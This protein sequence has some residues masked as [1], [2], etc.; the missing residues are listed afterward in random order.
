MAEKEKKQ[1]FWS[2]LF[3][4]PTKKKSVE[5]S[6]SANQEEKKQSG[7]DLET[8]SNK[9]LVEAEKIYKKGLSTIKDVIAPASMEILY[10]HIKMWDGI[11]KSFFVYSYPRFIDDN[12]LSP[13]I[14]MDA[15][16]DISMFIYPHESAAI[17]RL[18]RNKVAQMQSTINM[19]RESGRVR[20][21]GVEAALEDAENLRDQLQRGEEK[22]FQ[23]WLYFSI[24][25][26]EDK[27]M[28]K[29]ITQLET[30]L[31]S[32]LVLTKRAS[33]QMERAYNS[34]LP[35]CYD[36]L[37]ITRNMNTSPLSSSFPFS[38]SDLSSDKW[39]MYWINRHNDSL[40]IFDRFSLPN[41]NS[42]V[43]ST[44]WAWKSYTVKLE[45]LR[46]MMF[47]TD[48]IVIDPENEYKEL[49][50]TV[51]WTFISLS[52]NSREKINPFDLPQWLKDQQEQAWD[53]LRS[54]II[55][56][57]WILSLMLGSMTPEESS[58]IDKALIN[59][60]ALKW[61]TFDI[62]DPSWIEVP[63]MEDLY[64]VLLTTKGAESL[65]KRLE[66]YVNW[67]YSWI[68]NKPTNIDLWSWMIV[69]NVRDLEEELRPMAMHMLLNYIWNKVRSQLKKRILVVDEAWKIMQ[70][71][72]SAKFLFWLVK[73]A[74]KYYLWVTTIT[75]DVEDFMSSPY[76]KPI[77]TN[78]SMQILLKQA[79][80]SLDV[81]QKT[82]NLTEWEK[83]LLLN[84]WVWQGIFFAGNKHAAIQI[85]ASY[86]EDK[87][88]T[89][90]PEQILKRQ[91]EEVK[92]EK[93]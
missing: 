27:N 71:D 67:S 10:D 59:T 41:A 13:V 24:Y 33:M 77:V 61:I 56:L 79:P 25:E 6:N 18:L 80:S 46:L 37:E 74:R 72:A 23:Y 51:G 28:Q 64:S 58:L 22:F 17:L 65:A 75:Q 29:T 19:A 83:Y 62:E 26:R 49:C 5:V 85:I 48:I 55:N 20:D 16:M 1:W 69:F 21:P 91:S 43:L 54:S 63:V 84:S 36:Q 7:I 76:W 68:F 31:W 93:E 4:G 45:L 2:M 70:Y 53:L 57:S 52:L 66:K 87:V 73:R 3:F 60:Y 34:C 86:N 44:S 88:I 11:V 30:L 42:V 92:Y 50:D 8:I 81:L 82:F 12:W 35:Y 14:N 40:I 38:S 39:I 47:N 90:N 15:T 89:T 78:S 9:D 32:K